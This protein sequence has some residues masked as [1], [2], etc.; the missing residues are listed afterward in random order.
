MKLLGSWRDLLSRLFLPPHARASRPQ[1]RFTVKVGGRDAEAAMRRAD[2]ERL[3]KRHKELKDLDKIAAASALYRTSES[4]FFADPEQVERLMRHLI[5]SGPPWLYVG[6]VLSGGESGTASSADEVVWREDVRREV[7]DATLFVPDESWR[8]VPLSSLTLQ[9]ARRLED[10]WHARLLDQVLPPVVLVDRQ[11]RGEILVPVRR[12][13]TR[14]EFRPVQRRLEVTVRSRFPVVI[15]SQGEGRA[16]GQLLYF[17]LDYSASMRG[18]NATLAMAVIAATVRANMGRRD[19]RY[20][21]RRFGEEMWPRVVEPPIQARTVQEK[22]R[23]L[24]LILETNFNGA[25][26]HVNDALDVAISDIQNLRRDEQLEAQILL[27]TDGRAE[28]LESTVLKLREA[29]VKVHTVMV[30]PE[31]NSGL[32]SVSESY[33]AL[34]IGPDGQTRPRHGAPDADR[35]RMTV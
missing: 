25:A 17:L 14:L 23:L 12:D 24:D 2:V 20:L 32:E 28:I 8:D 21:F 9:P 3:L 13:R 27:V 4:D 18:M 7:R 15:E 34:D 26:T 31:R 35:P 29:R 5:E 30:T 22:D 16:G 33:T 19:T 1:R 10:V 11:A 6:G